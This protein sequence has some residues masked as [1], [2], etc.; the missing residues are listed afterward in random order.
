MTWEEYILMPRKLGWKH[1]YF[2]G[3]AHITPGHTVVSASVSVR[4]RTFQAP[5]RIRAL[6]PGDEPLLIAPYLAAYSETMDYCD[7]EPERIDRSARENLR[8]YFAERRGRPLPASRAAVAPQAQ[9]TEIVGAALLVRGREGGALLDML[10]VSPAWHRKGVATALVSA[11]V[12]ALHEGGETILKSR[13]LLGNAQS[14]AWHHRFGCIE[15]PDLLLANVY[16]RHAVH[17]LRR[18]EQTGDLTEHQRIRLV[19]ERDRYKA[20]LEELEARPRDSGRGPS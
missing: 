14:R 15:E 3:M 1:E 8:E 4:P 16:Y 2:H 11:V 6:A 13:Y 12:N 17:E 20:L 7:W 10:F 19:A 5:C 9:G 18:R